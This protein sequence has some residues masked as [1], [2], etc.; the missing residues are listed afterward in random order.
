MCRVP[1]RLPGLLAGIASG[2]TILIVEGEK[3]VD[4]L[5]SEGFTT[6]CNSGGAGKFQL[7][8]APLFMGAK[9]A[10]LP[11]NDDVGRQHAQEISEMLSGVAAEIRIVLVALAWCG[12]ARATRG[13]RSEMSAESMQ[14]RRT[15]PRGPAPENLLLPG[16][17][18]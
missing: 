4:R 8:F 6:T 10:I 17:G 12:P 13:P 14:S 18:V 5:T 2:R 9:V 16:S 15:P 3:D 11:D 7:E 1:Y